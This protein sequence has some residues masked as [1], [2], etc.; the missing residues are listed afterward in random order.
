MTVTWDEDAKKRKAIYDRVVAFFH[1]HRT[2][3]GEQVCQ[4]DHVAIH[5]LDF[6]SDLCD[7][8]SFQVEYDDE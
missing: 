3:Y 6:I 1:E 2:Y 8:M 7:I 5:S 4:C